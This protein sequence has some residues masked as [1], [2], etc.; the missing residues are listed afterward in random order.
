MVLLTITVAFSG[1]EAYVGGGRLAK[2]V[3]LLLGNQKNKHPHP[4][5]H[6]DTHTPTHTTP[7]L[8]P[9]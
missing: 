4:H 1:V 9:H 8:G 5:P 6:G 7:S 3:A 2:V